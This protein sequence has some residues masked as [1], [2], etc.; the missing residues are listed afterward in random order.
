MADVV[1]AAGYHRP[2]AQRLGIDRR[3]RYGGRRCALACVT[4]L[5]DFGLGRRF[6]P[7]PV[8]GGDEE[9]HERRD[10]QRRP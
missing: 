6:I 10:G 3:R 2:E 5:L 8:P 1:A 7:L 4:L 9:R